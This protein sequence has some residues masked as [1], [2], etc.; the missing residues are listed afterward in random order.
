M[1]AEPIRVQVTPDS[2]IARLLEKVGD[3]PIL[4]E[5][6]GELYRLSKEDDS[7]ANYDPQ[8]TRLALAKSAGALSKL[9][10][11]EFLTEIH[12]ARQQDSGGRP[13]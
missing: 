1:L 6:N 4:L 8:R 5:K 7:W 11:D 2:E 13:E 3:A 9:D 12:H 10:R